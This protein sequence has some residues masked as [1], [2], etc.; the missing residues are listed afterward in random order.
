MEYR[1]EAGD[2]RIK[3][4][5]IEILARARDGRIWAGL[6]NTGRRKETAGLGAGV[7]RYWYE[8]GYGRIKGRNMGI[9]P[10]AGKRLTPG[11]REGG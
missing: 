1:Q 5:G 6:W 9:L 7:W 11:G 8:E 3:G 4:T 2:R 10:E